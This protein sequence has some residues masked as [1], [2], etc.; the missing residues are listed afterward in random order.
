ML[1]HE[2]GLGVTGFDGLSL[3]KRA[4]RENY[5]DSPYQRIDKYLQTKLLQAQR[6]S[7]HRL[8]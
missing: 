5:A 2:Y 1:L 3:E 4:T 6:A 7:F 8:R